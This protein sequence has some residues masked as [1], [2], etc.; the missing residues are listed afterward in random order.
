VIVTFR[1][2]HYNGGVC[3]SPAH[4]AQSFVPAAL[5]PNPFIELDGEA[6]KLLVAANRQLAVPAAVEYSLCKPFRRF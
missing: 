1:Y 2:G 4:H 6:V 5:P 3:N